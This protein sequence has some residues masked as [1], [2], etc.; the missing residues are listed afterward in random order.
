MVRRLF[1]FIFAVVVLLS[2][3][4]DNDSFSNSP[5]NR[6]TFSEDTVRFDTLFSTVPSSTQ[7]FWVHNESSDGIRI[8]TARLERSNQSGYRVNVDGTYLDP[9]GSDFEVRKGDSLLVFVEVTT[10]ENHADEPQLVEDNLIFTLESGAQQR[11]NLRTYSWDAIRLDSLVVRQDTVIE[12]PRPVVVYGNG[13]RVE[14]NATL[15]IRNTTLYFHDGAG[16]TAYGNVVAENS[17]FRG[18]RL[19]RMFDYLPYDHISGQWE[20]IELYSHNGDNRFFN[21]EIRNAVDALMCDSTSLYMYNTIVH[22]ASGEGLSARNSDVYVEYCQFSNTYGDCVSFYGCE[23]IVEHST[24]AQFY[25]FSANRGAALRFANTK[26][27]MLLDCRWTLATGYA[28][29]VVMGE[30][31]ENADSLFDYHFADCMLRTPA[32]EDSL[33][34]ER[35][36]WETPKDSVQGKEHFVLVD[37]ENL[38]YDFALDSISPALQNGI[39]RMP[40][41]AEPDVNAAGR[42]TLP[43]GWAQRRHIKR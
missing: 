9:V 2:A 23:A 4:T 24:L 31:V 25:P 33:R 29:D 6:L 35:V 3:C 11:V 26:L 16:I 17:L 40:I 27:P 43:V 34:F 36:I 30:V 20:G 7:T 22:N 5:G 28:D 21:C 8:V 42:R 19:D 41:P 39:G 1:F 32:V 12:S 37:E 13:I 15:T 14:E 18:D 10:R 38:I